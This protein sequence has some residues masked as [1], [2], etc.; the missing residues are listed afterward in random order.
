MC[1]APEEIQ[2]LESEYPE[3]G[4]LVAWQA[5]AWDTSK[6]ETRDELGEAA[7]MWYDYGTEDFDNPTARRDVALSLI[8]Y[9]KQEKV[10]SEREKPQ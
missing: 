5:K 6:D 10:I 1:W 8:S 7:G 4:R 9:L 3:L 2:K